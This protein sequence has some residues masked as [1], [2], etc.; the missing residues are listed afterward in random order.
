MTPAAPAPGPLYLT[1]GDYDFPTELVARSR[2]FRA[3]FTV[4]T[5]RYPGAFADLDRPHADDVVAAREW[6]QQ[7]QI[8]GAWVESSIVET[9]QKWRA[10]K[11]L[12]ERRIW[13]ADQAVAQHVAR[14]LI[15]LIETVRPDPLNE[16]FKEWIQRATEAWDAQCELLQRTGFVKGRR[17]NNV[18]QFEWLAD[19]V[20]GQKSIAA[21]ATAAHRDRTTVSEAVHELARFIDLGLPPLENR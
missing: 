6:A 15:P 2:A 17:Q 8:S 11:G 16:G 9:M 14:F 3:F 10:F 1:P 19:R 5:E 13:C 4:A 21:I 18:E 12:R 7:H 20:F